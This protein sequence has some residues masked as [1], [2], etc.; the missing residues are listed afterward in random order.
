MRHLIIVS[1]SLVTALI[2][3]TCVWGTNFNLVN[4]MSFSVLKATDGECSLDSAT[5]NITELSGNGF[6]SYANDATPAVF[7]FTGVPNEDYEFRVNLLSASNANGYQFTPEGSLTSDVETE[8]I[9]VGSYVEIN[10]GSTGIIDI[11][12]GGTLDVDSSAGLQ[13]SESIRIRE[14]FSISWQEAP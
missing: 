2:Y 4:H 12:I 13:N 8:A 5:G 11:A 10:A 7:K 9:I 6:C 1:C 14:V 3:P